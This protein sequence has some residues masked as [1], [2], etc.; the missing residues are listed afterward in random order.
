MATVVILVNPARADAAK[1]ASESVEW[2]ERRRHVA[3]LLRLAPADRA[4]GKV[5]AGDLSG[6]DLS[7]A[8][9]AISLGGD[10]TFLRLVPL[11]YRARVPVLGVNFGRLGYLLEIEPSALFDTLDR[12]LAGES[13]MEDRLVMAVTVSGGL[14]AAHGD[15]RSL[16]GDGVVC[17]RGERW[18]V[19]LNEMVIEKTVPGHMVSL[20]TALDG[21]EFLSYKADGVIVASPT[22]STAYNLSAGGPVLAPN[23]PAMVM[24]PVAPHLGIDRSLVLRADQEVSVRVLPP[25]PAVLVVD[26]RETGRVPPG[27]EVVCRVA[28][29]WLRVVCGGRR[30]FAGPLRRA[31]TRGG[32]GE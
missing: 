17:S 8:D 22:G 31:L 6:A 23:L 21:E 11:A 2:L 4:E 27:A 26:G 7:G 28:P 18:W 20:A 19:A 30:G 12:T 24:T 3:R 32:A 16:E 5:P 9:L 15:D 13:A 29:G 10:G 1:L 25:R 14:T